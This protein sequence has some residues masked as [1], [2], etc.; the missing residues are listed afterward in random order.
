MVGAQQDQSDFVRITIMS[1]LEPNE[2]SANV[3]SEENVTLSEEE[4]STFAE[5][6]LEEFKMDHTV[7]PG[8]SYIPGWRINNQK[9]KCP[10]GYIYRSRATAF[11]KMISKKE[12]TN[13]RR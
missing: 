7:P 13:R 10:K 1:L 3:A 12:Y 8:W 6:G 4:I 5:E 11:E 2:P 9:F